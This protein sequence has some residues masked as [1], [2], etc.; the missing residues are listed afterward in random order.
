MNTSSNTLKFATPASL[1]FVIFTLSGFS[2]L[3]YES[4]WSHYLKLFLGHAAYA[5]SLVLAIFMGGMAIGAW[6]AAHYSIKWKAPILIYALV[7]GIIGLCALL[8]H[9]GF[10]VITDLIHISLLPAIGSTT[11]AYAVKWSIAAL[12]IIP[13][14]ILLG[15][16][17]PLMT[18]GVVRRYPGNTGRKIA[19]LYFCN[20]IGAAIG[21]LA[22][23][24]WLI[25]AIGLPGAIMTAGL[26]NIALALSVWLI[27]QA[28]TITDNPP[29]NLPPDPAQK[30]NHTLILSAAFITGMASFIYEI[31]WIRMLGIALGSSTHA[32]ELML[33]AFITGLALGGLWIRKRIDTIHSL[34]SFSAYVQILMGL[35]ALATLWV[36]S[37]TF[38]WISHLLQALS[39][40]DQGY[41]ILLLTSHGIALLVMLPATFC[42]GMTL[43]LFTSMLLK[44]GYGEKSIGRIY[45]ANTAGSI[46]GVIFAVNI[47]L[48]LL[49]LK[50]LISFGA[51]LDILLGLVLLGAAASFLQ[52]Q[53][54]L[55]IACALSIAVFVFILNQSGMQKEQLASGVFRY[56][57]THIPEDHQIYYY[58]DGKTAS[59]SLHGRKD[60][61]LVIATNGKPDAA[62]DYNEKGFSSDEITMVLS[63]AL[64]FGF[65]PDATRIA[66]I[67]MG[68][69][70]T[71]HTI[72]AMPQVQQLD[73]IEIESAMVEASKG[74]GAKI[75]RAHTD[76]RSNIHIEDAKTF[77]S[78]HNQ[79]YDIIVSEPSNPWVSGVASLFSQEFYRHI[80]R[81]LVED[82]L[83]VQW[84]HLYE[85]NNALLGSVLNA[86]DGQFA[87][88]ALYLT[89][90]TDILLIA[91]KSGQLGPL[92]AEALLQSPLRTE[93]NAIGIHTAA[94]LH[95]RRLINKKHLGPVLQAMNTPTNSDFFPYLDLNAHKAFFLQHIPSGFMFNQAPFPV[96][97]MLEHNP[98]FSLP[99]ALTVSENFQFSQ[100]QHAAQAALTA[101]ISGTL[102]A[103]E[104]LSPETRNLIISLQ[105]T[106][107][108]CDVPL[109]S[110][111]WLNNLHSA[112]Q[113]LIKH[114]DTHTLRQLFSSTFYTRCYDHAEAPLKTWLDFY[115]AQAERNAGEM[116]RLA[117]HLLDEHGDAED[118]QLKTYLLTAAILGYHLNGQ[119]ETAI[120]LWKEY[121]A[122]YP[123]FDSVPYYLQAV[124]FS[125]YQ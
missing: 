52:Q 125:A 20:S 37:G 56:G 14:S 54:P 61:T 66:N 47:G 35:L 18:A 2:G 124:V 34:F 21:V 26:I 99:D 86:L 53:K 112:A 100:Q 83:L 91:R 6:L 65:K 116:G 70:L 105:N 87:D 3:I 93:L 30:K 120:A 108:H 11:A 121:S 42:A 90:D 33:S 4:L 10:I 62:I 64:P 69:G 41:T 57:R 31:G 17:F 81:Y 60:R 77:F 1:Y 111:L 84:L 72:L 12:M 122:L 48:P 80:K 85:S 107:H 25:K 92:S 119:Q 79:Q 19:F 38:T 102:P 59:I 13:Q 123:D 45:A 16:T 117:K 76:P 88:Y 114:L 58:R 32:F 109:Y 74:F 44:T 104:A 24:F 73:T 22:S 23:G 113:F 46:I 40:T 103:P 97:D 89:N 68:S 96:I 29:I 49:G 94:D 118:P 106:A 36:Y 78:V 43:P 71:T 50:Y 75:S 39:R 82:G 28:D 67:G 55:A 115:R 9:N 27:V 51:A 101:L 63:G 7:E 8:F 15:M 110:S 98:T 5:Q 95:Y